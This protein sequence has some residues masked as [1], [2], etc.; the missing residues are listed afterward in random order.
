M[1]KTDIPTCPQECPD[2]GSRA[3]RSDAVSDTD[4]YRVYECGRTI[5][6]VKSRSGKDRGNPCLKKPEPAE[7]W[8][9]PAP[10]EGQ[11]WHRTDWTQDMLEGGWRPLL[12]GEKMQSETDA[13]SK[14]GTSW[15]TVYGL[16]CYSVDEYFTDRNPGFVRT[17]RP[18]I[19]PTVDDGWIT[20]PGGE[21]PVGYDVKVDMKWSDGDLKKNTPAGMWRWE[22]YIASA[23]NII[24]YRLAASD[25]PAP[26][27]AAPFVPKIGQLVQQRLPRVDGDRWSTPFHAGSSGVSYRESIA[28][29][30][31]FRLAED[32][33]CTCDKMPA[34][35]GVPIC[36]KCERESGE[37]EKPAPADEY[38]EARQAWKDGEL[39]H[40]FT[41]D[42]MW[43]DWTTLR[44]DNIEPAWNDPPS[45]YR[46][47]PKDTTVTVPQLKPGEAFHITNKGDGVVTVILPKPEP[48]QDMAITPHPT[49]C[50]DCGSPQRYHEMN[51]VHSY[52]CGRIHTRRPDGTFCD[53]DTEC[54]S[55]SIP[56]EL[57]NPLL[58]SPEQIALLNTDYPTQ[59]AQQPTEKT[60]TMASTTI[61]LP[62]QLVQPAP[63]IELPP[64]GSVW[65]YEPSGDDAASKVKVIA[66]TRN[67]VTI[68]GRKVSGNYTAQ[69]WQDAIN[70][71][72]FNRLPTRRELRQQR[73]AEMRI[74]TASSIG[75]AMDMNASVVRVVT[76]QPKKPLW[77]R[78][79][80]WAIT[81]GFY[82]S[83][84]GLTFWK[85]A[86]PAVLSAFTYI[87]GIFERLVS[88]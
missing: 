88:Q 55:K 83:L 45:H 10:P 60:N 13:Y 37:D 22:R 12:K 26:E 39:Q 34:I 66:S 49:T 33:K 51:D 71:A 58:L 11:Q 56:I 57:P 59:T 16:S 20:W 67:G 1:S 17:K 68:S 62:G 42:G 48:K 2:C 63:A 86:V 47:K 40:R 18:A 53:K 29:G 4:V 19:Q 84:G 38:A 79:T 43:H 25:N 85:V 5:Y 7:K 31:E 82:Y 70:I 35:E 52:V 8:T 81:R 74:P 78:I 21:C 61:P 72:M 36:P 69:Q 50:P 73:K 80:R 44:V 77:K 65:M 9:L 76:G 15:N 32:D 75:E 14:H 28:A 27:P 64:I 6:R 54:P 41:F 46:R 30:W 23:A 24:A 3:V 87:A